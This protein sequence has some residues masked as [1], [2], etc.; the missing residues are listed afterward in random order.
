MTNSRAANSPCHHSWVTLPNGETVTNRQD[1]FDSVLTRALGRATTLVAT[2]QAAAS[3]ELDW[4]E[5]AGVVP[6]GDPVPNADHENITALPVACSAPAGTFFDFGVIHLVTT[7]TL[8]RLGS[9]IRRI[10]SIPG[11]F[12]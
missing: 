9:C 3:Y 2:P 11:A 8:S 6:V 7:A 12:V 4:P 10:V 5:I 1:D